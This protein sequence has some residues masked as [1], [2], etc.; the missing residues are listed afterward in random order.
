MERQRDVDPADYRAASRRT[1]ELLEKGQI[2][3]KQPAQDR[4]KESGLDMQDVTHV[5]RYGTVVEHS[6]PHE[7]WRYA[8]DGRAVDGDR[9]RCV[10][11]IDGEL[12]LVTAFNPLRRR[13]KER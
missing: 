3:I 13:K 4:M 10:V 1:K 6:H 5:L 2:R 7:N 8:V 9:V 12:I 11:E